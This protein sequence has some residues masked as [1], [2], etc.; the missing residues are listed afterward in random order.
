MTNTIPLYVHSTTGKKTIDVFFGRE[1]NARQDILDKLKSKQLGSLE[2]HNKKRKKIK[3]YK[4]GDEIFVKINK[5]LRSKLSAQFR[6]E[7]VK[8]NNKTT[9]LTAS[10]KIVY[11]SN[12]KND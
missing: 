10:G 7:I 1:V 12:I 5:R 11:K 4:P 2:W 8:E 6:K 3:Q 9:I